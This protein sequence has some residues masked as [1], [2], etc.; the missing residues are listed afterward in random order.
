MITCSINR[1]TQTI[2]LGRQ[3]ENL[4][5]QITI[6]ISGWIEEFGDGTAVVLVQRPKESTPYP[7]A[8]TLTGGVVTWPVTSADTAIAG[9]GMCELQYLIGDVVVKSH[10][11]RTFI[12]ASLEEAGEAPDPESGWV[13]S[14]LEK[15]QEMYYQVSGISGEDLN[16]AVAAYMAENPVQVETTDVVEQDNTL[17][18]T[19]GG[20]YTVVGNIEALRAAL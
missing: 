10:T 4:A 9:M 6:D 11:M 18:V 8:I 16:K 20:V 19:S 17:P 15:V 3:G 7:A 12:A 14:L 1:K 5:R 13:A 2:R